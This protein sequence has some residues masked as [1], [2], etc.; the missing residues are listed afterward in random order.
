MN[1]KKFFIEAKSVLYYPGVLRLENSASLENLKEFGEGNF[2]K[3]FVCVGGGCL[4]LPFALFFLGLFFEN[5]QKYLSHSYCYF[6]LS[7][8]LF[9]SPKLRPIICNCSNL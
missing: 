5:E 1:H 9:P 2:L 8:G 7:F 4:F 3:T 6:V